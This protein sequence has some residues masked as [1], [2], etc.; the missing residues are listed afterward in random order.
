MGSYA[1]MDGKGNMEL[2]ASNPPARYMIHISQNGVSQGVNLLIWG[3]GV[4]LPNLL[5]NFIADTNKA[6]AEG[7]VST[8]AVKIA[9]HSNDPIGKKDANILE[10]LAK[11]I[12]S[13]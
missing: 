1:A 8:E 9:V 13:I 10:F 5:N 2:H 12:V 6:R 3:H 4:S 7:W 11:Y